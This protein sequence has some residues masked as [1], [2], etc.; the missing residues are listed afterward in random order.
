MDE[1]IQQYLDRG[2]KITVPV[3]IYDPEKKVDSSEVD[4]FLIDFTNVNEV[5]KGMN[6]EKRIIQEG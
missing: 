4:S 5:I 6:Y 3:V 2:G 1:T